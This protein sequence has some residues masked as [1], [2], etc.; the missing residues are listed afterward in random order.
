MVA[1]PLAHGVFG[2]NLRGTGSSNISDTKQVLATDKAMVT[3]VLDWNAFVVQRLQ[4]EKGLGR[5]DAKKM[6]TQLWQ[7]TTTHGYKSAWRTF[8]DDYV[9]DHG[10]EPTE[11]SVFV[12][13]AEAWMMH[14]ISQSLAE[15]NLYYEQLNNII[16]PISG[17]LRNT[18]EVNVGQS[19]AVERL[20]NRAKTELLYRKH[21]DK[22]NMA[23][24]I[25]KLLHALAE[26]KSSELDEKTLRAKLMTLL[27][28]DT[29]AR[30]STIRNV[31]R[32][33]EKQTPDT[34]ATKLELF[35]ISTKDRHAAKNKK[36]QPLV[37]HAFPFN[38]DICTIYTLKL[39]LDKTRLKELKK[40]IDHQAVVDGR[41]SLQQGTSIFVTC[42]KPYG[43][44]KETTV[45]SEVR[46]YIHRIFQLKNNSARDLRRSVPSLLQHIDNLSDEDIATMF[47]WH[48]EDTFRDW[49]KTVIPSGLKDHYKQI[50]DQIP[51]SWKLRIDHVH[52]DRFRT[53]L[54]T[55]KPVPA[56]IDNFFK[57][58]G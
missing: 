12:Q 29:A 51:N 48:R 43:S 10:E 38:K 9:R 20:R 47:R 39:Y 23:I 6:A 18:M 1:S 16:T 50:P 15:K 21:Q 53:L 28:L 56:T 2:S 17:T 25:P 55:K 46:K 36:I 52:K 32:G 41:P 22:Q 49:Y 3:M 54:R 35:P 7:K 33:T 40:D 45:T 30:P 26:D 44:I 37:T 42:K 57:K 13:R 34:F 5:D 11:R 27:I 14:K 4:A 19:Q 31:L 8:H 24:D 58:Q